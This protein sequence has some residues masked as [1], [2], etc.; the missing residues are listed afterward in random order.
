[1]SICQSQVIPSPTTN[2]SIADE[3]DDVA[4][5]MHPASPTQRLLLLAALELRANAAK[6]NWLEANQCR[7]P[8]EPGA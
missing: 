6:I 5:M 8:L 1:M 2:K 3:L 7:T 4:R